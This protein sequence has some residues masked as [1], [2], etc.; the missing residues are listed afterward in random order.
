[1]L[2]PW[3]LRPSPVFC[4]WLRVQPSI[5]WGCRF[6]SQVCRCLLKGLPSVP[7]PVEGFAKC[8]TPSLMAAEFCLW[9]VVTLYEYCGV[10]RPLFCWGVTV[11]LRAEGATLP[12]VCMPCLSQPWG[13]PVRVWAFVYLVPTTLTQWHESSFSSLVYKISYWSKNWTFNWA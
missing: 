11:T 4:C 3:R 6:Q 10:L 12:A 1:M 5:D 2:N 7:L 9:S 13:F 8:H